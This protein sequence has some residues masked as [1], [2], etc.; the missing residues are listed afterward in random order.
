MA[1]LFSCLVAQVT[2]DRRGPP[3]P[4][5]GHCGICRVAAVFASFSFAFLGS[6]GMPTESRAQNAAGQMSRPAQPDQLAPNEQYATSA[7]CRDCLPD[8]Y[9]SWY[10]LYPV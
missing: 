7:S 10:R 1:T 9:A 2:A 3:R 5:I 6:L 4:L 8:Q